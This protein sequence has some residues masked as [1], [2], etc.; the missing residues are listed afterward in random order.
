MNVWL[1]TFDKILTLDVNKYYHV[2]WPSF[3]EQGIQKKILLNGGQLSLNKFF[4]VKINQFYSQF[5]STCIF[6]SNAH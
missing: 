1:L 5:L 4:Q 6:N 2:A 3:I